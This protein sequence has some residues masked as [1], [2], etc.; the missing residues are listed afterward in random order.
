MSN[1]NFPIFCTKLKIKSPLQQNTPTTV[2]MLSF[3][4]LYVHYTIA[5][6]NQV[7][8]PVARSAGIF[9]RCLRGCVVRRS[10]LA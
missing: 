1:K 10:R 7:T 6:G 3:L 9:P 8:V 5:Y 4:G 2:I